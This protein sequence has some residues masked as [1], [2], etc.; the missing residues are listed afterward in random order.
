[1]FRPI[2]LTQI[3]LRY[4]PVINGL[5]RLQLHREFKNKAPYR[6]VEEHNCSP[7]KNCL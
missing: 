2:L 6:T 1:M 7:R 4:L 3:S 5:A